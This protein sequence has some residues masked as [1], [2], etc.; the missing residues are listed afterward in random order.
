MARYTS[1]SP[2]NELLGHVILRFLDCT[3]MAGMKPYLEAH[4]LSDVQPDHWYP[5]QSWLD[6]LN[7]V[8]QLKGRAP[9]DFRCIGAELVHLVPEASQSKSFVDIMRWW[10]NDDSIYRAYRGSDIGDRK[11]EIVDDHHIKIIMRS[12]SPDDVNYGFVYGVCQRFLP[13]GTPFMVTYDEDVARR[14]QGG[15]HTVIHVV[16]NGSAP[17]SNQTAKQTE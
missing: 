17:A 15:D 5:E 16:W 1:L 13:P 4:G 10:G 12:A 3:D 9:L 8:S 11:V 2:D 7:D 6:V 14:D